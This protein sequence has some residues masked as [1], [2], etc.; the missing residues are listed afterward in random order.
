MNFIKSYISGCIMIE[1]EI[2]KDNRGT[3]IKN[4]NSNTFLKNN[5]DENFSESYFSCSHKNVLRGMHFQKNPNQISKLIFCSK[6]K[7]MDVFLDIRP[8]SET[9]GKFDSVI[10]SDENGKHIYLSEGIA[11]G[12]LVLSEN[13]TVHYLQSG[14]YDQESDSGILWNSFGMNWPID[15][16]ILSKRDKGFITF[17]EYKNSNR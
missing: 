9:F 17:A 14:V 16:P 7:V 12:F 10:L 2:S 4:F 13:A 11:H 3:F 1:A 6:G 8:D 5:I 15:N